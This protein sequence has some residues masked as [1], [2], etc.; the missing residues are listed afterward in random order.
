M[1]NIAI[2]RNQ[3]DRG[4]I[5]SSSRFCLST[6]YR[7][8]IW[9]SASLLHH[10]LFNMG[11]LHF[12]LPA[13]NLSSPN[14]DNDAKSFIDDVFIEHGEVKTFFPLE[15]SSWWL[16]DGQKKIYISSTLAKVMGIQ[17]STY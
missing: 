16:G 10:V 8:T 2:L 4:S 3:L 17:S 6:P 7:L 14:A 12:V 5:R 1:I 15:P 9:N 13:L 11:D